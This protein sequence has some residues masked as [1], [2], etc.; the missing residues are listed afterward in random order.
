MRALRTRGEL[1]L[2]TAVWVLSLITGDFEFEGPGSV[3]ALRFPPSLEVARALGMLL[4]VSGVLAVA[5]VLVRR[6]LDRWRVALCVQADVV[7]GLDAT[8]TSLVEALLAENRSHRGLDAWV[9]TQPVGLVVDGPASR[10]PGPRGQVSPAN[11][12]GRSRPDNPLADGARRMG[13]LV[14]FGDAADP[15]LMRAPNC[16]ALPGASGGARGWV[17]GCD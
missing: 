8:T 14:M 6:Q 16:G 5:S 7:V 9:D 15:V 12:R 2:R 11:H 13:A 17:L 10:E 1:G 3:C 4:T